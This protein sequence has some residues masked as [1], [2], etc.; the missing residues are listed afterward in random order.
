MRLLLHSIKSQPGVVY[1]SVAYKKEYN[2]V[3]QSS[4]H[5]ETL[6]KIYKERGDG[7]IGGFKPSAH[8]G[9]TLSSVL[10]SDI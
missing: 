4:K 8:D 7:H 1:K 2:D 6:E 9:L 3:L 10:I 5:E